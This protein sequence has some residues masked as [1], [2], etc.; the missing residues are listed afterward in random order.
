MI[1]SLIQFEADGARGVAAIEASGRARIIDGAS[2]TLDLAHMAIAA[3]TS[4]SIKRHRS[5]CWCTPSR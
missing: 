2:S 5:R 4:P 1:R 3:R